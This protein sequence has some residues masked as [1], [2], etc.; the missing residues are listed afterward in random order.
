M[1]IIMIR[2]G[3]SEDNLKKIYSRN[4]TKLT[5]KGVEQIKFIKKV[6]EEYSYE[7]VY[8]SPLTRTIET[9]E[10]LGLSGMIE[11][12]I[13]EIDFGIFT[14]KTYSQIQEA[15]PK[16]TDDWVQNPYTYAI[17]EGESLAQVNRRLIEFLDKIV[18]QGEDTLLITHDS[19]IKLALCWVLDNKEYFY[20]FKVDNGSLN[21]ITIH[22]GFKYINKLNHSL[23]CV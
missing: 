13:R 12:G 17:P 18:K 19:I 8:C 10:V 15:C 21:I 9:M 6:L 11:P 20:K 23:Y 2:H 3:E 4:H 14:G 16:E 7:K 5:S 22:E 1:D